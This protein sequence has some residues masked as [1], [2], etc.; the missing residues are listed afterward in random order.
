MVFP[1]PWS[2]FA[3]DYAL[4]QIPIEVGGQEPSAA[5]LAALIERATA[6]QITVIFA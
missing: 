5:E 2:Y 6:E 4:E 1:P 3:H